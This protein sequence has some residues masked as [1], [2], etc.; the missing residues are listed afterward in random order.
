V[1]ASSSTV[2]DG[3]PSF[4]KA[5]IGLQVVA[6]VVGPRLDPRAGVPWGSLAIW[7]VIVA[8]LAY[9][10]AYHSKVAWV[11]SILLGTIGLFG[12]TALLGSDGWDRETVWFAWGL[13]IGLAQLA[14]LLSPSARAWIKEPTIRRWDP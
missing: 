14:I 1:G 5:W 10:L 9:G 7:I 2:R 12:A 4:L 8:A 6:F 13:L 3:F 11:L